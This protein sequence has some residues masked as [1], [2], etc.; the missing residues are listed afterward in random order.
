[1]D[2]DRYITESASFTRAVLLQRPGRWLLFILLGVPWLVLSLL[3]AG[4]K[5]IE[6]VTIHW[7]TIPVNESALLVITGALCNFL[8]SGYIVRLLGGGREPPEFEN[9][10]L[11]VLDGIKVQTIILV[12]VVLPILLA[13]G[14]YEILV[15]G[16][17][18]APAFLAVLVIMALIQILLVFFAVK[19]AIIG[20]IRFSRSGSVREAFH[21]PAIKDTFDRIG[22]VNYYLGL[23]V[24]TLVFLVFSFLFNLLALIPVAGPLF[25]L[26]LGPWLNVFC[27]RFISHFCDDDTYGEKRPDAAVPVPLRTLAG[28]ISAWLLLLLVLVVLCGTPLAVIFGAVR[29]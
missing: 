28:E 20:I 17:Q 5:V 6:G 9:W 16:L 12:W 15:R 1:M 10:P 29:A 4:R 25:P 11:L 23:G 8:I 19:Y 27:I 18:A 14:E 22:I 7:S 21:L 13:F 3:L 2:V 24:I 26:L